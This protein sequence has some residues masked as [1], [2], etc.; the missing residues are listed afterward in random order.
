MLVA[1]IAA[2]IAA[3][4]AIVVIAAALAVR[5]RNTTTSVGAKKGVSELST[6]GVGSSPFERRTA[7]KAARE[8]EVTV[9]SSESGST[10]AKPSDDLTRRFAVLGTTAVAIFGV[11]SA[12]L[13]TMQIL[14]NSAY[15]DAAE[16]NLYTTVK[17][18]APRGA[19]YDTNGVA[20]VANRPS[21]TV[22]ADPEVADNRDVIRRLSA[23]LGVPANVVSSRIKDSSAGAQSLRVVADDVR[24]RDVAFIAEHADAFPGISVE[25]R[26]TREYPY[27]ALA[28]HVLGYTASP[29]P[30]KLENQP[31]GR[32]I[33]AT[34]VIGSAGV[35]AYYDSYLSG[36]HGESKVMVDANGRRISVMSDIK[37]AKGSDIFL[38]IDA[39]AQY[40]AD[41]A[42]ADLIAPRGGVIGTGT[43]SKGAVVA[44]DVTDGSVLVMASYPTFDPSDFTGGVSDELFNKYMEPEAYAPLN[45]NVVSGQFMAASTFKAFTSLAGLEYGFATE[46]SSW[47][48]TGEWDGFGT[49]DVQK[50]WKHEGH[51]TLD[52]HG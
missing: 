52:L 6:V 46:G 34:D 17:T 3:V 18:P 26:S 12:K 20:L 23:V 31:D 43:G 41:K 39:K 29:D 9:A 21:Q 44:L 37:D 36:E 45:N 42:L 2:V 10:S 27:G 8:G 50:C 51:G 15:A 35:E 38:T 25:E 48:C 14:G 5:S 22:V 28:A 49:G 40:V 47:N 19:I 4:I 11:L 32:E 1:I 13:W 33:L 7:A 30:E 16:Q 24:L